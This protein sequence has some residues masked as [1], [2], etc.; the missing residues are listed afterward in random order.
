MKFLGRLKYYLTG[1]GLGAIM[2]YFMFG[3]RG[4]DWTPTNRVKNMFKASSVLVSE[5]NKCKM[6]CY[7]IDN[8]TVFDLIY[9]GKVNFKDSKTKEEPKN[10]VFYNSDYKLGF[11]VNAQ[12]SVV[13]LTNFF[14]QDKACNCDST[15]NKLVQLFI[16]DELLFASM[17]DKGIEISD[18]AKCEMS[19]YNLTEEQAMG[20]FKDGKVDYTQSVPNR[21]PN[22]GYAI[23]K[24]INGEEFLFAVEVGYKIRI[25]KIVSM[26]KECGC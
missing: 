7:G 10:Y 11:D 8:S 17:I 20:I 15:S 5:A 1:F 14:N 24:V 16:S 12:D 23:T 21:K 26:S 13:V 6:A 2:V 9:N 19:C 22:P 18:K 25:N 4:C 3:T